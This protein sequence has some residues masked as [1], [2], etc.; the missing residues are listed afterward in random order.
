MGFGARVRAVIGALSGSVGSLP[1]L[2]DRVS[3]GV[4]LAAPLT[5]T[6]ALAL[7]AVYRCCSLLADAVSST[8]PAI[9]VAGATGGRLQQQGT[10][11]ARALATL[12]QPDAE[13]FAFGAALSGNGFLRVVRDGTGAPASLIGVPPWRVAMQ[14]DDRGMIFYRVAADKTIAER[15]ILVPVEDMVH[16]RFRTIGQNRFWGVPPAATC[17]S[18]LGLALASRDVQRFLFQNLSRPG[19]VLSAPG[20]IDP[21]VAKKLQNEWDSNFSNSGTGKVAV[22]SNGLAYSPI[23]WNAVDN[24]LLKQV[25][26][27]V[28]DVANAYGV[29]SNFLSS[30]SHLTYASSSEAT[31]S[32]YVSAL[33]PFV[34][35]CGDAL[36]TTLLSRNDR[37]AGTT[38]EYD[39]TSTLLTPGAELADFLSKLVA[40]GVMSPNEARN[41]YLNLPDIDGGDTLRMPNNTPIPVPSK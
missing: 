22:L 29:P 14:I 41:T 36:A 23:L 32:L 8:P 24:Q 28:D 2:G 19:G 33:K 34:A 27:S 11:A 12:A 20:K 10:A 40:G 3:G 30:A 18:A 6:A 26:A 16:A 15:E 31:K 9:F 17:S 21:V 38:I 39:L 5:P 4:A 35:R 37:A 1:W 7:T 25:R 13:V